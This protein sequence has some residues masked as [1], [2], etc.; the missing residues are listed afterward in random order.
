MTT[1]E[2]TTFAPD[3]PKKAI[4]MKR[5]ITFIAILMSMSMLSSCGFLTYY[6]GASYHKV[7]SGMTRKEVIKILGIPKTRSF[8]KNKE[9]LVYREFLN[10][11]DGLISLVHVK[12]ENDTVVGMETE[13]LPYPP[14]PAV[15]IKEVEKK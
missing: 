11:S 14:K 5:T 13:I 6:D 4:H 15:V 1:N 12:L 8:D 7:Q 9:D 3:K 10:Y 2:T